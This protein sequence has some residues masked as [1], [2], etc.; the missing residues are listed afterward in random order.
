MSNCVN[1]FLKPA[2]ANAR[3]IWGKDFYDFE[4]LHAD[5]SDKIISALRQSQSTFSIAVTGSAGSGKTKLFSRI[6]HQLSQKEEAFCIY[7]NADQIASL[8]SV[9]LYIQQ[10]VIDSLCHKNK[11]DLTYLQEVAVR[12]VNDALENAKAN[13]RF[14]PSEL[15]E[16]FEQLATKKRFADNLVKQLHQKNSSLFSNLNVVRALLWTLSVNSE[17]L[18][19]L[20]NTTDEIPLSQNLYLSPSAI[21]WLKGIE[22]S[23]DDANIMK[24]PAKSYNEQDKEAEALGRTLQLLRVIGQY[25]PV[26]ICF[27]E[28]DAQK[29]TV[30]TAASTVEVIIDFIKTLHNSLDQ[31]CCDHS[32]L[33]LSLWIPDL[34]RKNKEVMHY[35]LKERLCSF[36]PLNK[37][38]I[39]L[40]QDLLNAETG[41]KLINCWLAAF[42]IEDVENSYVYLG[43][44]EKIREFCN[45]ERPNP[46]Q[47]WLWCAENWKDDD[48][49]PDLEVIYQSLIDDEY[50]QLM[51]DEALIVQSLMFGLDKAI[52]QTVENV[53]IE[54]ITTPPRA[55]KFQFKIE[56]VEDG[57][58]VSIGVGVCQSANAVTVG[59][60]VKKL[61]DDPKRYK[62]TR[63]CLVRSARKKINETS[64]A[65]KNLK[66]LVSP[67]LNG[68]FVDL[69][70]NEVVEI[71][72]LYLLSQRPEIAKLDPDEVSDFINQKILENELIKEI[73]SDPSGAIPAAA[74]SQNNLFINSGDNAE[75]DNT[76]LSDD[77]FNDDDDKEDELEKLIS[78]LLSDHYSEPLILISHNRD[79]ETGSI[80][81]LFVD[82][83]R[84]FF[85]DYQITDSGVA[86]RPCEFISELSKGKLKILS[87]LNSDEMVA[88]LRLLRISKVIGGSVTI[89]DDKDFEDQEAALEIYGFYPPDLDAN[90]AV[91]YRHEQ[92]GVS[93]GAQ[94]F[95][96]D[97]DTESLSFGFV[98]DIQTEDFSVFDSFDEALDFGIMRLN[99]YIEES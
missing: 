19:N 71:H 42:N 54:K 95:W 5:V 74:I 83:N 40:K 20:S 17:P 18:D 21:D 60:M 32:T 90:P 72:A 41:L 49:D 33:I 77:D 29:W 6:R 48:I 3:D 1:P 24:L 8:D 84:N 50:S 63:G 12:L 44:E 99:Y 93:I 15:L 59:A 43:G 53:L 37:E 38:A 76:G 89:L 47:L 11:S 87:A 10:F 9:C 14:S 91:Y 65:F 30:N 79:E 68:E 97:D 62:L 7:I 70:Y 67:P 96:G 4:E 22:I 85:F 81:G 25:K 2:I 82:I 26:V 57:R 31:N 58:P 23:A 64:Q 88:L 92:L 66:K 16:K 80:Y 52:G 94:L 55:A 28:L 27:D 13:K 75:D 61:I 69:K 39:S 46:R 73:L 36:P 78:D 56:G 86:Y 35:G 34:W 51:E 45:R 98:N